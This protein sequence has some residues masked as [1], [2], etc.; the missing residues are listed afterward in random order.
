MNT[1]KK[2]LRNKQWTCKSK[3]MKEKEIKII[4][5]FEMIY[6]VFNQRM[7]DRQAESK[8][9][10]IIIII[11]QNQN[12]LIILLSPTKQLII[13]LSEN[14]YFQKVKIKQTYLPYFKQ[15]PSKQQSKQ[16]LAK[17]SSQ[18]IQNRTKSYNLIIIQGSKLP[19]LSS[20]QIVC[21]LISFN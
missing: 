8:G 9:K 10:E 16:A 18:N 20:K 5:N 21:L 3:E 7:K 13:G 1:E 14:Q 15:R 11:Q 19:I 4:C 6:D 2:I 17:N 12:F